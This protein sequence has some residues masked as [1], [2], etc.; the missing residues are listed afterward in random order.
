MYYIE[1]SQNGYRYYPFWHKK[2]GTADE[3]KCY[4]VCNEGICYEQDETTFATLPLQLVQ[5]E[6]EE[7][8]RFQYQPWKVTDEFV[9]LLYQV[10]DANREKSQ[11][12]SKVG[13][14]LVF[15]EHLVEQYPQF[16]G[17]TEAAQTVYQWMKASVEQ[18]TGKAYTFVHYYFGWGREQWEENQHTFRKIG[19]AKLEGDACSFVCLSRIFEQRAQKYEIGEA[20][21]YTPL[22]DFDLQ[23]RKDGQ[24]PTITVTGFFKPDV[25]VI[26][27]PKERRRVPI[28]CIQE[29]AFNSDLIGMKSGVYDVTQHKIREIILSEQIKTIDTGAFYGAQTVKRV[30]LPK[31]ITVIP[32]HCFGKCEALEEVPEHSRVRVIEDEAFVEC[33]SLTQVVL[34]KS[35]QVLGAGCFAECTNLVSVTVPEGVTRIPEFTFANCGALQQVILPS[36]L[37]EIGENAFE[38]CTSL[39]EIVLPKGLVKLERRAFLGCTKLKEIVIPASVS[40]LEDAFDEGITLV[41]EEPQEAVERYISDYKNKEIYSVIRPEAEVVKVASKTPE[42]S[43]KVQQPHPEQL[44]QEGISLL[45]AAKARHKELFQKARH[46]VVYVSDCQDVEKVQERIHRSF[47]G[48]NRVLAEQ[49]MEEF[50]GR[51]QTAEEKLAVLSVL[52]EV[53]PEEEKTVT[54][55]TVDAKSQKTEQAEMKPTVEKREEQPELKPDETAVEKQPEPKPDETKVEETENVDSKHQL[56]AHLVSQDRKKNWRELE[57]K[58]ASDGSR[59]L[60]FYCPVVEAF[61]N[62]QP[63]PGFLWKGQYTMIDHWRL[64][65]INFLT[66]ACKEQKLPREQA[67]Q[68]EELLKKWAIPN[69]AMVAQSQI[70]GCLMQL[71]SLSAEPSLHEVLEEEINQLLRTLDSHLSIQ[72]TDNKVTCCKDGAQIG[73]EGLLMEIVHAFCNQTK[74]RS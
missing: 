62:R 27:V 42:P 31:E 35:V 38:N 70:I 50:L 58:R 36:S 61:G 48:K 5:E 64:V 21:A 34:S 56:Y 1:N 24:S 11:S 57:A 65:T 46:K 69:G 28:T 41:T 44:E 7:Y 52:A 26:R 47:R 13:E 74:A 73:M 43:E 33:R 18:M 22:E 37:Q 25:E 53:R 10:A 71:L 39:S 32:K 51:A 3:E 15:L 4:A 19:L 6:S 17:D 14:E 20:E 45:E 60:C 8:S 12:D 30:T 68:V 67:R 2:N 40:R 29:N 59:I 9:S 63:V 23:Q 16:Q 55:T 66:G 72:M 54:K 49:F